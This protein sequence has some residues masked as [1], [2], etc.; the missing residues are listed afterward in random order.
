MPDGNTLLVHDLCGGVILINDI[1]DME[2]YISIN[3]CR[4]FQTENSV[5]K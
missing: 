5:V 4:L 3:A 1:T 2:K